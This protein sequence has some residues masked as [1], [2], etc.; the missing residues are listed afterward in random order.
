MTGKCSNGRKFASMTSD[1]F[2]SN[3]FKFGRYC[4]M[5][6]RLFVLE[7]YR[8][9]KQVTRVNDGREEDSSTGRDRVSREVKS[10]KNSIMMRAMAEAPFLCGNT[11]HCIR[12]AK[13]NSKLEMKKIIMLIKERGSY[14]LR[15]SGRVNDSSGK[16]RPRDLVALC[17]L[18]QTFFVRI[19]Q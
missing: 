18:V 6:D 13:E 17:H 2:K 11:A 5:V 3:I 16:Q 19:N 12:E 9:V 10:G 15:K 4:E 14:Q 7:R 8:M 1:T